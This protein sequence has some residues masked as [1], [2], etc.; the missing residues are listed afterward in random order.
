MKSRKLLGLGLIALLLTAS[1]LLKAQSNNFEISKN[2]DIYSTLLKELD[3]NY[4]EP[5]NPGELTQA[6]TAFDSA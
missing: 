1:L 4:A 2:L 5:I 3:K 6:G